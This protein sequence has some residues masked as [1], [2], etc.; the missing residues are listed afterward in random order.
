MEIRQELVKDLEIV[1]RLTKRDKRPAV[2]PRLGNNLPKAL[3]AGDLCPECGQEH[4][5]YDGLLN[6]SCTNCGFSVAGVCT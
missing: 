5:D 6:L 4:L 3:R 1:S 2:K